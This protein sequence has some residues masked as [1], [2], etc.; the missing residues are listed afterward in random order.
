LDSISDSW[1]DYITLPSLPLESSQALI[2]EFP[3]P[4]PVPTEP[5][6][7]ESSIP[8]RILPGEQG[9]YRNYNKEKQKGE[10]QI[11]GDACCK[12]KGGRDCYYQV[13]M[14]LC[15]GERSSAFLTSVYRPKVHKNGCFENDTDY[16]STDIGVRIRDVN[17]AED[18]QKICVITPKC[19]WFTYA[20][21]SNPM[22]CHK[23]CFLKESDQGYRFVRG[24]TSGPKVC[25]EGRFVRQFTTAGP[26]PQPSSSPTYPDVFKKGKL[27]RFNVPDK[28]CATYDKVCIVDGKLLVTSQEDFLDLESGRWKYFQS[29]FAGGRLEKNGRGDEFKPRKIDESTFNVYDQKMHKDWWPLVFIQ[30]FPEM[31]YEMWQRTLFNLVELQNANIVDRNIPIVILYPP[32]NVMPKMYEFCL[33]PFTNFNV[34]SWRKFVKSQLKSGGCFDQILICSYEAPIY[35]PPAISNKI[36]AET[37]LQHYEVKDDLR[38]REKITVGLVQ[39]RSRRKISNFHA[40]VQLCNQQLKYK[41]VPF[42]SETIDVDLLKRFRSMHVYVYMHGSAGTNGLFLPNQSSVVEI[43]PFAAQQFSYR[44]FDW[45]VF[46]NEFAHFERMQVN[47]KEDVL[48]RSPVRWQMADQYVDWRRLASR[49]V[50]AGMAV[51]KYLNI[52]GDKSHP[53][54]ALKWKDELLNHCALVEN[55]WVD[56]KSIY[57]HEEPLYHDAFEA[58]WGP[59]R[60][61]RSATPMPFSTDQCSLN[62][63]PLLLSVPDSKNLYDLWTRIV[64][65]LQKL[66]MKELID[67]YFSL[68]LAFEDR[69]HSIPPWFETL[70]KPF[71]RYQI[72]NVHQLISQ[73]KS[74]FPCF[75]QLFVCDPQFPEDDFLVHRTAS[76]RISHFWGRFEDNR[77]VKPVK[78]HFMARYPDDAVSNMKQLRN[79]CRDDELLQNYKIKCDMEDYSSLDD[80]RLR[81]TKFLHILVFGHGDLAVQ[82]MFLKDFS[83]AIELFPVGGEVKRPFTDIPQDTFKNWMDPSWVFYESVHATSNDVE[84]WAENQG[85]NLR[86]RPGIGDFVIPWSKLRPALIN[87]IEKVREYILERRDVKTLKPVDNDRETVETLRDRV[88]KEQD[89]LGITSEDIE[90]FYAEF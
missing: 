84:K 10:I 77:K 6:A 46:D 42:V 32:T 63:V 35:R 9:C 75:K 16:H 52:D 61:Q 55:A 31:F 76:V 26:S 37:I 22:C 29:A 47:K 34:F 58:S 5:D 49:I 59:F 66:Q 30:D 74:P 87:G 18:C 56:G 8:I 3:E 21:A 24:F 14:N 11:C 51:Q 2:D 71:S 60:I 68:V 89:D 62:W 43:M 23:E 85:F 28:N 83:A 4:T 39:R 64:I 19:E 13:D 45:W 57:F 48:S 38:D 41:C 67:D 40:I 17:S 50:S 1:S 33:K 82:A 54:L 78:V 7:F 81:G 73:Y 44:I 90:A 25:P 88:S 79:K 72:F 36:I 80:K 70:L 69:E 86:T 27:D 12:A 53:D 65:P 20:E 15:H